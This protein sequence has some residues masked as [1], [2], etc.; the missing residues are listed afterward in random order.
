M[1]VCQR[2][3]A[4]AH[5]VG[6][7]NIAPLEPWPDEGAQRALH[8]VGNEVDLVE[9]LQIDVWGVSEVQADDL[10]SFMFGLN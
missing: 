9:M 10:N 1:E 6:D 8:E 7:L 5:G 4:L 3:H 2:A